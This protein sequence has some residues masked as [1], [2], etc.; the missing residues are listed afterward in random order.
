MAAW[1][2]Y[3]ARKQNKWRKRKICHGEEARKISAAWQKKKNISSGRVGDNQEA[4]SIRQRRNGESG[5]SYIK[6]VAKGSGI[7]KNGEKRH[8]ENVASMAKMTWQAWLSGMAISNSSAA[9]A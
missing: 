8:G 6:G 3:N 4:A 5:K 2:K 7:A 1:L 9:A